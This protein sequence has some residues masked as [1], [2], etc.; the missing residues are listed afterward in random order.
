VK[1]TVSAASIRLENAEHDL[2]AWMR[3]IAES[4]TVCSR[5]LDGRSFLRGAPI[6]TV[7]LSALASSYADREVVDLEAVAK[8]TH[9]PKQIVIG[10]RMLTRVRPRNLVDGEIW[11]AAH[12]SELVGVAAA[13]T[14][15]AAAD[16]ANLFPPMR[17]RVS[18]IHCPTMPVD[19]I[20]RIAEYWGSIGD[21]ISSAQRLMNAYDTMLAAKES[22]IG[23]GLRQVFAASS[24][25]LSSVNGPIVRFSYDALTHSREQNPYDAVTHSR[26]QNPYDA[27]THSREQN[28]WDRYDLITQMWIPEAQVALMWHL[29]TQMSVGET[30]PRFREAF[31]H[32]VPLVN[33]A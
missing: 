26:E 18:T 29:Q 20:V 23:Q 14:Y 7:R 12:S 4:K 19:S 10:K 5:R 16:K 2:G 1:S 17:L 21:E 25:R 22:G 30:R 15:A 11:G 8:A 13:A 27:V 6:H 33:F 9:L 32:A 3:Q 28:R 31:Q 24:F